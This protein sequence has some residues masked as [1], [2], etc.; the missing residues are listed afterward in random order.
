MPMPENASAMMEYGRFFLKSLNSGDKNFLHGEND[1]W[2]TTPEGIVHLIVESG[3]IPPCDEKD[4][5]NK[6]LSY[7]GDT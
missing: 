4:A 5:C 3:I 2:P 1:K 6:I 7:I